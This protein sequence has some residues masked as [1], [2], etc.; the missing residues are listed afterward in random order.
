M[1]LLFIRDELK[2]FWGPL[3]DS[4]VRFWSKHFENVL[5]IGIMISNSSVESNVLK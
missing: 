1:L 4:R 3:V 5:R 2:P